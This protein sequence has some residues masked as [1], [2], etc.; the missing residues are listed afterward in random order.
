M[1]TMNFS[2]QPIFTLNAR[3]NI[4]LETVREYFS[5]S[6]TAMHGEI[7]MLFAKAQLLLQSKGIKYAQLRSGLT[8]SAD[9]NEAAFIFNAQSI[10]S[11][12]YGFE[13]AKKIIPLH[14]KQSTQ[15]VLCGDLIGDDKQLIFDILQESLVLARSFPLV[16]GTTLFCVYINNLSDSALSAMHEIL[17]KYEPYVGFIPASFASRAK[18][19]LSTILVNSYLKH[20]STI[21][22]G[23]EDDRPNEEDVNLIGYPFEDFGY[24]V[25]SLPSLYAG[26]FLGYKI[27]RPLFPGFEIDTEI[28]LNA[29]SSSVF[30]IDDFTVEIEE[31]K[32]HY[33]KSQKLGKLQ[34]AGIA[35]LNGDELAHLIRT[36]ITASYI[37]NLCY[38]ADH[39]V[40]K[41]NVMLEVPRSDDGY[42]TRILA[43]LEYQPVRRNLRVITLH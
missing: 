22:M 43:A 2:E 25:V 21:I 17:C 37:Y 8:P 14:D 36:K 28:S 19:Y 7:Q 34:K 41:F 11:P 32:L 30:P 24:R 9:R 18:A 4:F 20:R 38:L 39:D 40:V 10:D 26:L 12:C 35:E 16:H 13:I 42:P 3:G 15:S 6:S 27:E 23:H 33:L 31:A 5:L 29:V 1:P